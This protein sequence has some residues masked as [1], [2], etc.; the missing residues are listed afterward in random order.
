[1]QDAQLGGVSAGTP[2]CLAARLCD[3]LAVQHWTVKQCD[4]KRNPKDEGNLLSFLKIDDRATGGCSVPLPQQR[5]IP[6]PQHHSHAHRYAC[7]A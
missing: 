1:M 4:S 6:Q 5:T 7:G 2:T 3:R